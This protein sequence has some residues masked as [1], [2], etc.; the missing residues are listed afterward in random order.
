MSR[1][2]SGPALRLSLLRLQQQLLP[3]LALLQQQHPRHLPLQLLAAQQQAVPAA[4]AALLPRPL[5]LLLL[6]AATAL[7]VRHPRLLLH[8]V[9]HAAQTAKMATPTAAGAA[10]AAI[11]AAAAA[12]QQTGVAAAAAVAAVAAAAAIATAAVAAAAAAAQVVVLLLFL[13]AARLRTLAAITSFRAARS[14]ST[15]RL[16]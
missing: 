1:L 4:A 8:R 9:R 3:Q 5:L 15:R 11:T 7:Q 13:P 16:R 12:A 2:P 10:A 14:C 6:P